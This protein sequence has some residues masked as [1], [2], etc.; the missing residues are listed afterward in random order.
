MG[1]EDHEEIGRKLQKIEQQGNKGSLT[2][3]V[4]CL[5]PPLSLRSLPSLIRLLLLLFI[6]NIS[7]YF[8][9]QLSLLHDF[10]FCSLTVIYERSIVRAQYTSYLKYVIDLQ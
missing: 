4:V 3:F 9:S 7:R 2:R 1:C 6:N 10:L 5:F 8:S